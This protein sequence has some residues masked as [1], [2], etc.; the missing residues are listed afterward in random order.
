MFRLAFMVASVGA[1][2]VDAV[3]LR[4]MPFAIAATLILSGVEGGLVEDL[5]DACRS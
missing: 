3:R 2:A 4:L 5:G 1:G